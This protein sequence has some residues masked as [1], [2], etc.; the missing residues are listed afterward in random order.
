MRASSGGIRTRRAARYVALVLTVALAVSSVAMA[1]AACGGSGVAG[2]YK[3]DSGDETSMTD[4]KLT[5]KS[6]D[7]FTLTGPN[8]AGEGEDVGVS[9][10]YTLD[11]DKISLKGEEGS[12]E[13]EAG[14]VDGDKLVFETITWVKE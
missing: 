7:T 8:P 6:D 10:T 4:F 5:L 14:T 2:A 9:G 13:S 3:F 1:L 12:E 11:G